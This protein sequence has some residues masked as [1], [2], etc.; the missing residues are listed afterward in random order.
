MVAN[1]YILNQYS[2]NLTPFHNNPCQIYNLSFT[3]RKTE[4]ISS[5]FRHTLRSFP[6]N[7]NIHF[8]SATAYRGGGVGEGNIGHGDLSLFNS[9]KFLIQLLLYILSLQCIDLTFSKTHPFGIKRR[10]TK[11]FPQIYSK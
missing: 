8:P 11:I 10:W 9:S 6:W 4:K 3:K 7:E 2:Q 1:L 5:V